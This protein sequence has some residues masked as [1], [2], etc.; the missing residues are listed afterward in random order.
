MCPDSSTRWNSQQ[1]LEAPW[2]TGHCPDSELAD[3]QDSIKQF[4]ARKKLKGA[5]LGVMATNSMHRLVMMN[6]LATGGGA[7]TKPGTTPAVSADTPA[8]QEKPV[9]TTSTSEPNFEA[10]KIRIV[11]GTG[12]AARN[13]N[14][15]SDPYLKI[16]CGHYKYKS[17]KKTNTLTPDWAETIKPIPST[18]CKRAIEVECWDWDMI[19]DNFM[20]QFSIEPSVISQLVLDK[21][22]TMT[23]TL[24][25]KQTVKKKRSELVSGTITLE[26]T[27]M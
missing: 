15:K 22:E 4:Q 2:I 17:K 23:F 3:I 9:A 27:K 19:S 7:P 20:G 14:G 10:L 13:S 8:A 21:T 25:P 24:E 1:C 18:L 16:W 12:L 5:I 26:L 11:C 6:R